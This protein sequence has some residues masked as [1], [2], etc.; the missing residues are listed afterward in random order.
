MNAHVEVFGEGEL[1]SA[2]AGVVAGMLPERGSV[3]ITGGETAEA[4]YPEL[5][6]GSGNWSG[7][8]V[9][10]S[11]ERCVPPDHPASNYG[12]A[13]RTLLDVVRPRTVHRMRGEIDPQEA[14]AIYDELVV[15][16]FALVVLG[17]GEDAHVAGLFPGSPG[18]LET[19][20]CVVVD[21]PDGM[22]G[23]SLTPTALL[24]GEFVVFVVSGSGKAEA[25]HRALSGDE[26]VLE[27]PVK[28]FREHPSVTFLLDEAAATAL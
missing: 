22:Q 8:E 18:L 16:S 28:L 6:R 23:L 2:A 7:V 20:S 27:C 14:A 3:V 1:E 10:F 5:A 19:A 4:L 25:V 15:G 24:S 13:K 21:R 17:L 12:M 26:D 11:D 9:F